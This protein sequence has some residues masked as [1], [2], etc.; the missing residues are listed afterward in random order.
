MK[1]PVIFGGMMALGAV[2][3]ITG[4]L[5]AQQPGAGGARPAT[6]P[7]A[8]PV[9]TRIAFINVVQVLKNYQKAQA[10]QDSM[11]AQF[12]LFQDN[13]AKI[14]SQIEIAKQEGIKVGPTNTAQLELLDK[15]IRELTHSSKITTTTPK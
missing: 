1:K 13:E 2:G 12:K 5:V 10:F 4:L 9:T 14:R 8:A 3:L 7:T 11:K 6:A 15:R